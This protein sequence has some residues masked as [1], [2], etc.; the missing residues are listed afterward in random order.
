MHSLSMRK[1]HECEGASE[2]RM[3]QFQK[4]SSSSLLIDHAPKVGDCVVERSLRADP[5]LPVFVAVHKVGV[6]VV[7]AVDVFNL[8]EFHSGLVVALDIGIPGMRF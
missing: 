5:P 8:A 2:L 4:F 1:F 3:F 6:D 7:R